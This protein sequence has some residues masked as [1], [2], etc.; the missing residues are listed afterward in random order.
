MRMHLLRVVV[1]MIFG[2]IG[3]RSVLAGEPVAN[4]L[5]NY[6]GVFVSTTGVVAQITARYI[7]QDNLRRFRGELD[8]A[9][10]AG[11]SDIISFEGTIAASGQCT[12][13]G[14][15]D[16]QFVYQA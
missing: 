3:A 12:C 14:G 15:R 5:G 11:P 2:L 7:E 6:S 13:I 9:I 8:F 4:L 10:E 16:G 1:L